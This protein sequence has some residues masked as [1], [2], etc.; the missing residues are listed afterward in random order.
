M[1]NYLGVPPKR[2]SKFKRGNF[3]NN[4]YSFKIGVLYTLYNYA[5]LCKGLPFELF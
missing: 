2:Y 3:K 4:P 5:E 1:L